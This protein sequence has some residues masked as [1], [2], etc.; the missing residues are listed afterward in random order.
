MNRIIKELVFI[1]ALLGTGLSMQ[2]YLDNRTLLAYKRGIDNK[3][4]K[5]TAELEDVESG[6]EALLNQLQAPVIE[7]NESQIIVPNF[8]ENNNTGAQA[9]NPSAESFETLKSA[10]KVEFDKAQSIIEEIV[11]NINN[12]SKNFSSGDISN[13]ILSF[14]DYLATLTLE[15]TFCLVH[16]FAISGVLICLF[17]LASVF[18]AESLIKYYQLENKFPKLVTFLKIRSK[19]QQY[20]F[21]WNLFLIVTILAVLFYFNL[22]VF[23]L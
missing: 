18:Y 12:S 2:S 3:Q 15:Q 1:A 6:K 20:Y 21:A 8:L 5:V 9:T 13:Y 11:K 14:Q 17:N 7:A 10:A 16:L 22:N 23:L 19:F 4:P